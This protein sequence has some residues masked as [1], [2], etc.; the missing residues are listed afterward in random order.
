MGLDPDLYQIWHSSQTNPHQLN[1]CG[2]VNPEADDLIIRIR[3]E[4]DHDEQVRLC[5]RLHR[6]IADDQPYTFL[7]ARKWTALLNKR[8]VV[9][10]RGGDGEITRYEKVRQAASGDY[11]FDF[12]HWTKLETLPKSLR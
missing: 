5:R 12:L 11:T 1:F 8:I 4:Y 6:I 9:A 3:R 2:Y 10:R 7:Y